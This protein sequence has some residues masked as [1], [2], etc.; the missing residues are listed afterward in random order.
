MTTEQLFWSDEIYLIFGLEKEAQE[1]VVQKH[2]EQ[3]HPEDFPIWNDA[4]NQLL[5]VGK[6]FN[7]D[8]RIIRPD[9]EL[10]YI[11]AKGQAAKDDFGR[12]I[13][14]FG[15]AQDISD[16]KLAE[17][18][19]KQKATELEQT[20]QELQQTQNQLVESEKMAAL[21][22]LVAGVAHEINTPLGLGVTAASLLAD[23]IT[24]FV[25][26]Y[27]SGQVKRSDFQNFLNNIMQNSTMILSNLNRAGDLIASFKQVAVDQTSE[28][29]RSFKIMEYLEETLLSLRSSLKKTNHQIEINGDEHLEVSS[30]PGAFSQIVTNLVMNSLVHAYQNLDQGKMTFNLVREGEKVIFEYA[31]DGAGIPPENLSKIFEPFFTTKRN[32]GG[33][34]LGLHIV[35][36]LVTQKLQGTIKCDSQL[37]VGTKFS[38]EF[39][40]EV[41]N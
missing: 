14:V 6:P 11:Y 9:G 31:D 27:K 40:V 39:P 7:I 37:G 4:M 22:G 32:Q 24:D 33:S 23:K 1:L 35:Y 36:N 15:T 34:G 25:E 26:I 13:K 21:G 10:R 18:A 5:R 17:E 3:I 28:A 20:L 12:V 30:Y 38:I 16:R 2:Q 41:K 29:Q 19:L 8:F